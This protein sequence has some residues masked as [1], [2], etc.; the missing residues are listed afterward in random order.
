MGCRWSSLHA[1]AVITTAVRALMCR[2]SGDKVTNFR[3]ARVDIF[4][5]R[6]YLGECRP[7]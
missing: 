4:D 5:K 2:K 3:V 1:L 7:K 6:N